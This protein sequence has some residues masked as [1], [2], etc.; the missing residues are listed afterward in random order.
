MEDC[1][2]SARS[3]DMEHPEQNLKLT[4]DAFEQEGEYEGL[5]AVEALRYMYSYLKNEYF[6]EMDYFQRRP[7]PSVD[8]VYLSWS[9]RLKKVVGKC[10]THVSRNN[11]VPDEY[12]NWIRLATGYHKEYPFDIMD[13]LAHE[14]IHLVIS[15]HLDKFKN[16][17]YDLQDMGLRV[18]RY[19][20]GKGETKEQRK[21]RKKREQKEKEE[22]K[23]QANHALVCESCDKVYWYIRESK[24][25]RLVKRQRTYHEDFQN[26]K[27][28]SWR[29][30][31][32]RLQYF[33]VEDGKI[34]KEES[35]VV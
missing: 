24:R 21:E 3:S 2:R 31:P 10:S 6:N 30:C 15:G 16:R 20:R 8:D 32:G 13:T 17:L 19:S 7:L 9:K 28:W 1:I 23:Q 25:V 11:T 26:Y 27:S 5:P 12:S 4:M 14:M 22:K 33:E 35:T 34:Q 29:N 18:F